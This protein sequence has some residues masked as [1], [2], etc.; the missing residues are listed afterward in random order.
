MKTKTCFKC[1]ETKDVTKFYKH[2]SAVDGRFGKCK[3]CTKN[4]VTANRLKRI[5]F[6]REYDR[7]RGCRQPYEKKREYIKRNPEKHIAHYLLGNA[8][9]SGKI[10]REPCEACGIDKYIHGHHEDYSKPL[11]VTWLCAACHSGLHKEQI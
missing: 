9:R 10:K 7:K 8:I 2:R 4:D 6:Y 1:K 11:D 5:D 3:S